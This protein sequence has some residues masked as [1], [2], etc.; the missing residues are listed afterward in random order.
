MM[1]GIWRKT[2]NLPGRSDG[3]DEIHEVVHRQFILELIKTEA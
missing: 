3:G 1:P 2:V